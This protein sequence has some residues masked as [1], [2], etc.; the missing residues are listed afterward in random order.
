MDPGPVRGRDGFLKRLIA[1]TGASTD[2]WQIAKRVVYVVVLGMSILIFYLLW[3]L[4]EALD[5]LTP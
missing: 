3:S 1:R 2:G 5:L 4:D